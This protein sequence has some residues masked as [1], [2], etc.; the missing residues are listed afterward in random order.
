MVMSDEVRLRLKPGA[1]MP[2]FDVLVDGT[3]GIEAI[4]FFR[5]DQ[6]L[7]QQDFLA[8]DTQGSHRQTSTMEMGERSQSSAQFSVGRIQI[9][10]DCVTAAVVA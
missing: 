6:L 1:A 10:K 2:P 7:E 9:D 3:A 8:H 4:D 5:D